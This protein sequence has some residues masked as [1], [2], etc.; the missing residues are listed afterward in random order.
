MR[1]SA[2]NFSV[3]IA[4]ACAIVS[5]ACYIALAFS[6]K[7]NLNV[8]AKKSYVVSVIGTAYASIYLLQQ[9]LSDARYDIAYIHD[10]SGSTDPLLYKISSL[11]AGQEGSLLLWALLAGV[12]GLVLSRRQSP[13]VMAFW[14]SVQSFFLVL[15]IKAD[16]F[17]L[18]TNYQP[19]APGAGLNP[20]LKNPWMAIHPPVVF[21]GYA[22]LIV[23]AALA[24]S[25][26]IKGDAKS[27]V[28][29]CMPWAIFGWV[30]LSAG[31]VLGM[32]WSY[33]VLGWG[34]YWGWDPVENASLVPWLTSTALVHG[35]IL[36]RSKGRNQQGNIIL[37]LMT[38]LFVLYATFLT[39]SGV[40][41][42]YSVHS[43]ADLGTYSYLLTFLLVYTIFAATLVI[44]RW[45]LIS[46]K[47]PSVVPASRDYMISL[48]MI[49]LVIF[50]LIVAAG[51]SY[52]LIA[53]SGLQPD[54]YTRMSIP[55]A[56]LSV[57]L[58]ILAS[59]FAW[60]R[61]GDKS[62][63]KPRSTRAAYIAHAG[64]ILM[65]MGVVLSSSG[66]S[67]NMSLVKGGPDKGALDSR[68]TYVGTERISDTKE[69]INLKIRR[70]GIES[71]IPLSIEYSE[72]GS[73]RS[74]YIKSSFLGDMYISP[75]DVETNT[76]TPVASM[77]DRG[78]AAS[79]VRIPGTKSMVMLIGMQVESHLA[80]LEYY[81]GKGKPVEVDVSHGRPVSVDGYTFTFQRFVSSGGKDMR[82]MSAGVQ[83]GVS[84]KG[85]AEKVVIEV[86]KK[87][88][89]W[90]LWVGTILILIG[91]SMSVYRSAKQY[92][93]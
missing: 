29:Q 72:R 35:L 42:N 88:Y 24:V 40:L 7:K 92:T 51:T 58:I 52:P 22:A 32:I 44:S 93:S 36:Q 77:T 21:I 73:V 8:W 3:Y 61:D 75:G 71:T 26:L 70:A 87:P 49:V 54:F 17:K 62:P 18:L 57:V 76:I 5:F 84:G 82:T 69:V 34:G 2:D 78:W 66:K 4:F 27:W 56:A 20:L 1:I 65:V 64:V 45:R 10:Y 14:S 83:L 60:S 59:L 19:G 43:F 11:W 50:A 47:K 33:E 74:P 53:K 80:R 55:V 79:P 89:I 13:V 15:L 12:I 67:A 63:F 37:A 25:A 68:F 39:R 9:I 38:F 31:I 86:A 48:G 46:S 28:K 41:S 30:S 81:S 23:P 90:L 6:Q 16:P 85:I 91:G